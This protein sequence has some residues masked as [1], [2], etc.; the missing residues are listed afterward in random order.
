MLASKLI[1]NQSKIILMILTAAFELKNWLS[2]ASN[3][4]LRL[5]V[6]VQCDTA[7]KNKQYILL[8]DHALPLCAFLCLS[9]Y[10]R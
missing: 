9:F 6:L 10:I 1:N 3:I 7:Y 5:Q 4:W 8:T 2:F